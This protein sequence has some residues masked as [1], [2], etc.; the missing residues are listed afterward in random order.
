MRNTIVGI[1]VIEI[2]ETSLKSILY[3]C[4]DSYIYKA[5]DL[6]PSIRVESFATAKPLFV[7]RFQ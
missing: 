7:N 5:R 2:L 6:V 3:E 4:N 1:K